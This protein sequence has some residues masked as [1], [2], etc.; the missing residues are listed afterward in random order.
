ME[1]WSMGA[2]QEPIR[3][4]VPA[5]PPRAT[6][7]SKHWGELRSWVDRRLLRDW[8]F[9]SEPMIEWAGSLDL[10]EL[11]GSLRPQESPRTQEL[12]GAVVDWKP[13]ITRV[14]QGPNVMGAT[15]GQESL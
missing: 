5:E 15:W 6:E 3:S 9:G 2:Y 4:L 13:R 14:F 11:S 7:A 8:C 1:V 10:W 12:A